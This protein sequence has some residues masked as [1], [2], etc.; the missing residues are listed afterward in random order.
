MCVKITFLPGW[1]KYTAQKTYGRGG[2]FR[3]MAAE[4]LIHSCGE[5]MMETFVVE[6]CGRSWP[7]GG[8]RDKPDLRLC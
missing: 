6:V 1:S 8:D 4:G 2:L 3:V 5:R 7:C